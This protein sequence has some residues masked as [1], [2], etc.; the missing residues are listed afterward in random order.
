MNPLERIILLSA[1]EQGRIPFLRWQAAGACSSMKA[2]RLME[3][4]GYLY[5]E[6]GRKYCRAFHLTELGEKLRAEFVARNHWS[7]P[8][9]SG[10]FA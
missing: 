1:D 10:E 5:R 3:T 6:R 4:E 8:V 9:L 7:T 2:L